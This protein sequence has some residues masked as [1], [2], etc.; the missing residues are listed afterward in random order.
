MVLE[1]CMQDRTYLAYYG[2]IGQRFCV[3]N[4]TYVDLYSQL[5]SNQYEQVHRLEQAKLRNLACFFAHLYYTNAIDWRVLN[6]ITLT[7]EMTTA[8]SRIFIKILMQEIANNMGIKQF[9]KKM[10]ESMI[11]GLFPTDSV[12]N[13]RFSINFFTS[14]GLGAVTEKLRDFLKDAPRLLLQKKYNDLI[15]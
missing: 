11:E 13:A 15:N 12:E 1:C 3:L 7:E 6:C 2:H 9:A 10:D 4:P 5:F 14:I 8:S